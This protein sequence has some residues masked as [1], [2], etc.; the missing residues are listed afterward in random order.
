MWINGMAKAVLNFMNGF[1]EDSLYNISPF[2]CVSPDLVNV[3]HYFYKEFSLDDNDPK[4]HGEKF[5]YL[6]INKY[7]NEFIINTERSSGNHQHIITMGAGYIYW[8]HILNVEFFDDYLRI[9]D[10]TN[11]LQQNL[12]TILTFIEMIA[13]SC[14][15]AIIHV[16]ICMSF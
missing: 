2:L 8:N 10:N 14:F 5:R 11:I 1:L 16:A 3:I 7:P 4:E 15:F 9:K 12:F 6:M 13:T